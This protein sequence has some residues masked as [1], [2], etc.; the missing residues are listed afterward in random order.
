MNR[1]DAVTRVAWMVGGV[2][3]APT[4]QA[5]N[6]WEQ[7]GLSKNSVHRTGAFLTETQHEIMARVAELIIPRTDTPG[8]IDVGVPDFMEV[9]LRDC[10]RKPAQ[11]AF[12]MGVDKL[13]QKGFLKLSPEEQTATLK[14]IEADAQKETSPSFWL[15][16]KEVTLLGYYTSEAGIKASFDYQPIPG[17][18]EAIKIKPGQK[19]FM[20]GNQA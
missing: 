8:A 2:L 6:R 5:M 7:L 13:E 20:Y 19:D 10:Y 1:R 14:Q 18:F 3:S 17:K 12:L 4:I 9:M 11:D 15:I 16:T